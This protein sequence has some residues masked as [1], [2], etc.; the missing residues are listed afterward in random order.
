MG[1]RR[2]KPRTTDTRHTRQASPNLLKEPENKAFTADEVLFG[3]ITYLPVAGGGFCYLG[4]FQDKLTKRIVGWSGSARMTATLVTEALQM[5]L[6][7]CE[8]ERDRSDRSREPA[9]IDGIPAA[10]QAMP[11][12]AVDVRQGK[13]L[14]QRLGREL[15]LTVQD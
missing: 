9:R 11:P 2:F 15:V 1:P 10:S 12:A 13:L 7:L 8:A 5:A 14:R 3:D 6:R 4:M